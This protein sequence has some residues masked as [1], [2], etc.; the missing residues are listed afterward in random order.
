TVGA[1]EPLLRSRKK[2]GLDELPERIA[3]VLGERSQ[4]KS[5]PS[6]PPV[7]VL[8]IRRDVAPSRDELLH[9]LELHRGN[10]SQ[11][12]AFFGKGR[13]QVYRW[14]KDL[15]VDVGSTRGADRG[16]GEPAEEP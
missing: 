5:S 14:A 4:L 11:V 12:A 16:K 10:V 1:L 8:G 15:G 7:S 3:A 6:I 13:R 2:L 9:L